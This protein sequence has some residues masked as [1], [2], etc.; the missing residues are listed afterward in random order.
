[1]RLSTNHFVFG[2]ISSVSPLTHVDYSYFVTLYEDYIRH[3]WYMFFEI[4]V[5][6]YFLKNCVGLAEKKDDVINTV[7][8]I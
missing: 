8:Y 7:F 3:K 1:M 2:N 4:L 5:F 6:L